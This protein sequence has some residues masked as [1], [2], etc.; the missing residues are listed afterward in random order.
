[1]KIFLLLPFLLIGCAAPSTSIRYHTPEGKVFHV[2]MEKEY[3]ATNLYI[4]INPETGV[5]TITADS[6][7]SLSASVINAQAKRDKVGAQVFDKSLETTIK[8]VIKSL[9]PIP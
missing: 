5:V 1:M 8:A 6:W 7:E 4:S 9:A 2:E 3:K